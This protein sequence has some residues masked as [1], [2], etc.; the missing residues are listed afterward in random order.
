VQIGALQRVVIWYATN[1]FENGD[2]VLHSFMNGDRSIRQSERSGGQPASA[3]LS[4]LARGFILGSGD[5]VTEL[6][7]LS[8][9]ITGGAAVMFSEHRSN[10][11][12]RDDDP[13]P[14]SGRS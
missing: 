12:Y 5:G 1:V 11:S 2:R 13:I 10:K 6:S 4:G 7:R 8:S 3:G 14:Q 9:S